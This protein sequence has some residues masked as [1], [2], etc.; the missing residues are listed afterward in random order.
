MYSEV[1]PYII[2][3]TVADPG[4]PIRGTLI[5]LGS[6]VV[7]YWYFSVKTNVITKKLGPVGG[8]G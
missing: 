3:C 5:P 1:T 6:A 4:F 7:R 2:F 8:R